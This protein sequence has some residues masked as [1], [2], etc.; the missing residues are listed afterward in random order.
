[1]KVRC[2]FKK[3]RNPRRLPRPFRTY[4]STRPKTAP[5]PVWKSRL[6][7]PLL[8]TQ[9]GGTKRKKQRE[10]TPGA[11]RIQQSLRQGTRGT[12]PQHAKRK[13]HV[14]YLV[15]CALFRVLGVF[16]AFS[17]ECAHAL[18]CFP[19]CSLWCIPGVLALCGFS[20][21][22]SSCRVVWWIPGVLAPCGLSK[23]LLLCRVLGV[24]GYLS[25]FVSA[26]R[27]SSS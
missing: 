8:F 12:G 26:V 16:V 20:Y 7:R 15:V 22:C 11:N 3:E 10:R 17:P 6:R 18:C 27:M 9:P 21:V 2:A 23:V 19:G 14:C 25:C 24:R 13:S 4:E 1:M 5:L